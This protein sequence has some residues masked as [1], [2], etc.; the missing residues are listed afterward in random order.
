MPATGASIGTPASMS[1]RVLPQTEP[2][3]VEPLLLTASLTSR[4]V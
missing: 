1:A 2:I 3:L 4:K